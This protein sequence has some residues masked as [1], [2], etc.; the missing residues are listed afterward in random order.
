[1]PVAHHFCGGAHLILPVVAA[2][3]SILRAQP[4][5]SERGGGPG[6]GMGCA[7]F[8][9]MLLQMQTGCWCYLAEQWPGLL[10]LQWQMAGW[11]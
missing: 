2:L 8:F 9:P 11:R 3:L 7:T 6:S 5:W 1:M 10:Q 4:G